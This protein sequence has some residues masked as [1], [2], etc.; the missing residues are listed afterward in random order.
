MAPGVA[1][2]LMPLIIHS[3]D[4]SRV[5]R[6]G[7]IDLPFSTIVTDNKEGGFDTLFLEEVK[8]SGRV[9][10]GAIIKRKGNLPRDAAVPDTD[11]VWSAA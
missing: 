11:T 5:A 4:E 7:V 9:N 2:D 1:P 3:L 8:Q 10:I 6:L